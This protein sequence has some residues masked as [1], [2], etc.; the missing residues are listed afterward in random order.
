M[1]WNFTS[2]DQS[3]TVNLMETSNNGA[4]WGTVTYQG[5]QYPVAG[6]WQ[7]SDSLPGRSTSNLQLSGQVETAPGVPDYVALSGLIRGIAPNMGPM[8]VVVQAVSSATGQLS[9]VE[10]HLAT[11]LEQ[12]APTPVSPLPGGGTNIPWGFCSPDGS[13]SMQVQVGGDGAV[14]GTLTY[15][16][17]TVYAVSGRWVATG[18]EP[19][20]KATVFELMGRHAAGPQADHLLAAVGLVTGP[21]QRPQKID[22]AGN[23]ASIS[24][25][26]NTS[27]RQTLLPMWTNDQGAL[28]AAYAESY[29][30]IRM[31]GT[32]GDSQAVQGWIGPTDHPYV[33]PFG[34]NGY[35]GAGREM[36][37]E[38]LASIASADPNHPE[39]NDIRG[40]AF[41]SAAAV[42]PVMIQFMGDAAHFPQPP[43][44]EYHE[45]IIGIFYDNTIGALVVQFADRPGGAA[46]SVI[47]FNNRHGHLSGRMHNSVIIEPN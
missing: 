14:S 29:M 40:P 38:Q 6:M 30:V 19:G 8:D 22:I 32:G 47:N 1:H 7:A 43:L 3:V 16:G 46:S 36:T 20:R 27:F 34:A 21:Y 4:L 33:Y 12:P 25:W 10:A 44:Q 39:V 5:T 42:R 31:G 41:Q 13:V 11:A 37:A 2:D 35:T 45:D 17:N 26:T 24:D 28:N 15:H 9:Q 18:F 23:V